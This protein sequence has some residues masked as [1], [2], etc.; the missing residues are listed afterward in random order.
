MAVYLAFAVDKGADAWSTIA[1]WT[2]QRDTL[3][4]T[5]A[6]QA[7]PMI[8]DFAEG[9]PFSSSTGNMIS[10]ITWVK[11]TIEKLPA[12]CA[13]F[14]EQANAASQNLSLAKIISTDPPYYDNIGYA[15]LSDFFYVWLRRTLKP[16]FPNIFA[17]MT[18]PKSEELVATPYRHGNKKKA[19]AFFMDGMTMAIHELAEKAH[20]AFPVTIYYAFKQD[21]NTAS[22]GWETF[23]AAIITAG[24]TIT[25][26]W[27]MRTER[28]GRTISVG[29]NALA[30]S[31]V[32]VCRKRAKD[33]STVSRREFQRE[34]KTMLPEALEAM[35]GGREG[36][37]PIAPAD[38]AQ[39]AI[40]PGMAVFSKYRAVLEA[41]GT[42]M[43]VHD[44]LV[45]I[46]REIDEYFNAAEGELDPD[47][48]FC[49]DWF[50]QYGFKTGPF[51]EADVLARAKGT[52]VDD[53]ALAGVIASGG[54]SVRLLTFSDYPQDWDPDKDPRI[55]IWEATHQLI[56]A[57]NQGGERPSGALLARLKDKTEA[58]RQ[59]AYR[60]YTLCERR[61]WAEE[62]RAYNE[63]IC[64]WHAIVRASEA[65]GVRGEQMDLF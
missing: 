64:S 44:A 21:A 51:G 52:S 20:Q 45:Q 22:T 37:S 24:F 32:L 57:L 65:D 50:Q 18:V 23:L 11:K 36:A 9:N 34:L 13:G 59:L 7:I 43:R 49:I 33:A 31:I 27:P 58:I 16:I 54:G 10:C 4:N 28:I 30:S 55:P 63:L 60:L 29:T 53:V 56:R 40:G 35:I 1:S 61:K 48:R 46:N 47:S 38:L 39:A 17:T 6:R 12:V 15:D 42:S 8:W 19:E 5:F 62:A 14:S 3:R 26:T 25:G 41:D 2:P